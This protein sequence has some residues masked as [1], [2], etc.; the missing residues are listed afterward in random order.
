[1]RDLELREAGVSALNDELT[2]ALTRSQSQIQDLEN[3]LQTH[4]EAA[5][6]KISA[7]E[8]ELGRLRENRRAEDLVEKSR[9]LMRQSA[10]NGAEGRSTERNSTEEQWTEGKLTPKLAPK[11]PP[12]PSQNQPTAAA[13]TATKNKKE[14]DDFYKRW[15]HIID[16][17]SSHSVPMDR[18]AK[19]NSDAYD[20]QLVSEIGEIEIL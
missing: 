15:S 3:K 19:Q 12:I 6:F 7:L 17:L 4:G 10:E 13:S 11:L 16:G 14:W 8:K 9:N 2:H 18:P 5:A 20:M 1:M